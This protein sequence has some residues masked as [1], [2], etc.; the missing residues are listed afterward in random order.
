[1]SISQELPSGPSITLPKNNEIPS[2]PA[3]RNHI[4]VKLLKDLNEYADYTQIPENQRQQLKENFS[5]INANYYN[6]TRDIESGSGFGK[7]CENCKSEIRLMHKCKEMICAK[8]ININ[9]KTCSKCFE[10]LGQRDLDQLFQA[11]KWCEGCSHRRKAYTDCQHLCYR[12]TVLCNKI[13]CQNC[14]DCYNKL[15]RTE[16]ECCGCKKMCNHVNHRMVDVCDE[17][18][19]C[20]NCA[21]ECLVKEKCFCGRVL[22]PMEIYAISEYI[23]GQ[24]K[25]CKDEV[26]CVKLIKRDCCGNFVCEVCAGFP[27]DVCMKPSFDLSE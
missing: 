11:S 3:D 5:K 9:E 18:F 10:A 7:T 2:L 24:C 17:H 26:V 25:D 8:C 1:M 12:C 27:C 14:A 23:I 19:A 20:A 22:S 13:K 6:F 4:L 21:W 16:K 15:S